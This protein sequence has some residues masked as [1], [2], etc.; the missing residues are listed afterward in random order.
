[1]ALQKIQ[2]VS[3]ELVVADNDPEKSAWSVCK[4]MAVAFPF[5]FH[6][7]VEPERG[8][9]AVRNRILEESIKRQA[10]YLA[11]LDD[12]EIAAPNWLKQLYMGLIHYNADVVAG[13]SEQIIPAEAPAWVKKGGFFKLSEYPTGT[14]RKSASTRNIMFDLSKLC[15]LWRLRFHPALNLLGSSDTFFFEEAYDRGA[16]IVWIAEAVV[17]EEIPA[18][19]LT[20]Q[21]ILNRAFRAGNSLVVRRQLRKGWFSSLLL[22][23]RALGGVFWGAILFLASL[24]MPK[25]MS[26]KRQLLFYRSAGMLLAITGYRYYEYRQ[27]HGQ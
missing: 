10:D 27:T 2:D 24:P 26:L 18:S 4:N 6:Y 23:P 15:E 20:S 22:L 3:V 19:R 16:K 13:H 11:F 12:D 1:M 8:I 5:A 21:W 14:L 17:R 25:D 7:I 9:V